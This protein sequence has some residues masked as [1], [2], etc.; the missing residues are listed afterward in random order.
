MAPPA[1]ARDAA[2][3]ADKRIASLH[4]MGRPAR[5]GPPLAAAS[6]AS[7]EEHEEEVM[8]GAAAEDATGLATRG[9]AEAAAS[10]GGD[11]MPRQQRRPS[12]A[13]HAPMRLSIARLS[14]ADDGSVSSS[15]NYAIGDGQCGDV[16]AHRLHR[17]PVS[18]PPRRM[19][20]ARARR[21]G[22]ASY[23]DGPLAAESK[24]R[25]RNGLH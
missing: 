11:A 3:Q 10:E 1:A 20:P 17:S 8:V 18:P 14:F 22:R 2:V 23:G 6:S 25:H 15:K 9:E 19:P 5:P 16:P 12:G 7:D 24:E 13:S 21:S 4:I